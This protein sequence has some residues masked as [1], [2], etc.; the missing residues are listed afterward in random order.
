MEA[1]FEAYKLQKFD[2]AGVKVLSEEEKDELRQKKKEHLERKMSLEDKI[3]QLREEIINTE[4]RIK[5][6]IPTIPGAKYVHDPP[7]GCGLK[8]AIYFGRTP[9][10]GLAGGDDVYYCL[11][12]DEEFM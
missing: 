3:K 9:Q 4:V 7:S 2:D 8:T 11:F 5:E 1:G 6:E 12:C 10:G